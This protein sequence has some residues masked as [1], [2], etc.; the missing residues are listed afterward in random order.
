MTTTTSATGLPRVVREAIDA[1]IDRLTEVEAKTLVGR[2]YRR[3]CSELR[4]GGRHPFT[5]PTARRLL[6]IM[7]DVGIGLDDHPKVPVHA[8]EFDHSW[9]Q[10][11]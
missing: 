11:P 10:R 8:G 9:S 1:R 2:L 3:L 4:D 5:N 6:Q 7:A